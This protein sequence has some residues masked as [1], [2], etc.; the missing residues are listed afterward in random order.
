M[1]N[2]KNK[3][4][5]LIRFEVITPEGKT[6]SAECDSI[7]IPVC[8]GIKTSG[9]QYGIRKGHATAVISLGDG[10]VT[11]YLDGKIT[12]QF[13]VSGGFAKVDRDRVAV[14]TENAV[15][16]ENVSEKD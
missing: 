2:Q 3:D 9:G 8:D 12:S 11:A 5:K 1:Q 6:V 13:S 14:V 16:K 4:E 10:S 7:H 15:P